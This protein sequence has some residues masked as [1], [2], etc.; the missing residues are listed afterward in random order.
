[1]RTRLNQLLVVIILAIIIVL[2]VMPLSPQPGPAPTIPWSLLFHGSMYFFLA[3]ALLL[4]FHD[5]TKG[6]LEAI[7][8]T[9]VIGFSLEIVQ[10]FLPFR[11]FSLVDITVNSIGASFVLFDHHIDAVSSII[12][13]EDR[14]IE[15]V[16]DE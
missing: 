13:I 5:T 1:M 4:V 11:S 2:S 12:H 10:Y 16:T 8:V 3:G 7:I 9:A 15:S 14:L 6:H